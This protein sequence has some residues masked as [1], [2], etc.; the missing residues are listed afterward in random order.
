MFKIQ[1]INAWRNLKK[2]KLV[3]IINITGLT[4]GLSCA[5]LAILFSYHEL[6]YESCHEKADRISR[7]YTLAKFGSYD[8]F[9]NTFS[10]IGNVLQN[11]YPEVDLVARCRNVNGIAFQDDITPI[12]ENDI[13]VCD[14]SI[15]S[16]FTIPFT[17]GNIPT[18]PGEIVMS[19]KMAGKYFKGD[20]VEKNLTINIEGKKRNFIVTGVFKNLQS[21][22]HVKATFIIPFAMSAEFGWNTE[23]YSGTNYSVYT[24]TKQGTDI[25]KLNK[26]I[27]ETYRLPIDFEDGGIALVPVKR[28][29]L[30]ENIEENAKA[31]LLTL[32]FGGILSLVLSCFNYINLSTILFS[33]RNKEVGISKTI[34]AGKSEVFRQFMTDTLLT[35]FISFS[36]SVLVINLVL[37]S[38]NTLFE[39]DINI[40][41]N[42]KIAVYIAAIFTIT[43]LLSGSY[44]AFILSGFKPLSLIKDNQAGRR[45]HRLM[46]IL[47]TVQFIVSVMLLQFIVLSV[48]QNNHLSSSDI[49]GF[50]GT[51][52]LCLN[53]N[54][55]G[56]LNKVKD[57]LLKNSNIETVT[58][59]SRV[60]MVSMNT[61]QDWKEKGNKEM[62]L[63]FWMEDDYFK[64]FKIKL[65]EGRSFSNELSGE[66]KQAVIINRITANSLGY[67]D[68]VGK[69][70]MLDGK[71]VLIIGLVDNFQA[72][73]P[74][75]EDFPL[76]ACK[77]GSTANQ[78]IIRIG[79]NN[80]EETKSFIRETLV[81][82]NPEFPFEMKLYDDHIADFAKS[83]YTTGLLMN[84]FTGIIIF[85]AM[86]GLFGLSF[87]ISQRKN[88]EVGIRKVHGADIQSIIWRLGKGFLV[89]LILA[90]C[91]ASPLIFLAAQGYLSMFPRH[92][93]VGP[94]VFLIGGFLAF[95]ALL[96]STGIKIWQSAN[97]NP[98]ETLKYE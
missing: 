85:N 47:I 34:G 69:T 10:P 42:L 88:K 8:K 4:I 61:N 92:I 36:L 79:K 16:I 91:I 25:K 98:I 32:L 57:E 97:A 1:L 95:I 23:Q 6:N 84:V 64:A 75:F 48:K 21:S 44:P 2:N 50:D 83:Y 28:I 46:N 96:L 67:N 86:L 52:V 33:T 63:Q 51:G 3:S 38:F 72:Q 9:P 90:F 73:P 39:I 18:R 17:K 58:W 26:K 31:N 70:M 20:A 77:S 5:V 40:I 15:F 62:A 71:Q 94:E 93:K 89:K 27:A 35:S 74:I 66:D 68:P 30:Y 41:P 87:F 7:V 37:P 82:I 14:P 60:P 76:I 45:K 11:G 49:V 78:L 55:W 81:K 53:G 80:R 43:V 22:T 29:H 56:D 65:L 12:A 13:M 19:E 24:L 54:E 59:G